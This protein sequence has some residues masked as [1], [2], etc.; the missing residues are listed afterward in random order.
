M[1]VVGVSLRVVDA[2]GYAE[3]RDALSHDW[4]HLLSS[5][6][7]I[8][9]LIPNV[10]SDVSLFLDRMGV[11]ALLLTGGNNIGTLPNEQTE[12][13]ITDVSSERDGTERE[14]IRWAL[15]RRIPL[16]GICRGMQMINVFFE[17]SLVRDLSKTREDPECHV[18][19]NHP[20]ELVEPAFQELLGISYSV[21]N[22]YHEQTV[23]LG[24]L[25]PSLRPFALTSGNVVEGLYHPEYPILGIQWHPERPNQ[26]SAIDKFLIEGWLERR[27]LPCG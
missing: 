23:T 21:T 20:I 2:V 8:P 27:K 17:G 24:T 6:K 22:S 15:K 25:A 26:A 4:C 7:V 18:A 13:E 14:L 11:S 12:R 3:R 9:L 10:L 19:V 16:L 1:D 5:L